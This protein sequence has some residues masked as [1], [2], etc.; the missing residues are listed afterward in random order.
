MASR[1]SRT[2]TLLPGHSCARRQAAPTPERP[3][4]TTRTSTCSTPV[5]SATGTGLAG[6]QRLHV[7]DEGEPGHPPAVRTARPRIIRTSAER[8][9]CRM[10][11]V[12]GTGSPP[13]PRVQELL[14][15]GA[16]IA[17]DLPP[18]WL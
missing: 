17:L 5:G 11:H 15:Q 9:R 14:R 2:A 6:M 1:A 18:E 8:L 12:P 10:H 4:P 16:R 7:G 3:A 13:S